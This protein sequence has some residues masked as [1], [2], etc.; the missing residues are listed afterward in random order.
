[1]DLNGLPQFSILDIRAAQNEREATVLV[2][3]FSHLKGVRND[4]GSL[5]GTRHEYQINGSLSRIPASPDEI[6]EF[7]TF[8][9]EYEPDL[10]R[11]QIFPYID[12]YWQRYHV[13]LILAGRWEA[14]FF[15]SGPARYFR[16]GK[17]VGWQQP[18]E[19][20]LEGAV[21]LGIREGACYHE[22]CALCNAHIDRDN[23][24][25]YVDPNDNWLCSSCYERYA[26]P[27]DLSFVTE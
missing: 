3:R 5:Y 4:S 10:A 6:I 14:R 21:D 1:M 13:D 27:R 12:A 23:P 25:G 18:D 22:H 19:E 8:D 20:L 2:G 7:A 26:L 16:M 11:R 15:T 9:A 24:Q 17:T